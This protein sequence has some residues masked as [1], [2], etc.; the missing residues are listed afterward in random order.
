MGGERHTFRFV[1]DAAHHGLRIDT[2]LASRLRNHAPARLQRLTAAGLVTVDDGPCTPFRRVAAG[3]EVVVRLAEPSQPFYPPT[4]CEIDVLYDDP[5]LIAVNKPAGMIVHP[6][7]PV[8]DGTL[9]NVVQAILDRQTRLPGLLRPGIVHRLDRETSGVVLVAKDYVSHAGLTQQFER[10]SVSKSYLALVAGRIVEN[11]N[12][13]DLPIGRQRGSLLMSAE[14]DAVEPRSATTSFRVIER[15]RSA[16]LVDVRPVTGRKHQI[17]VH[18]A[19]IGHAVLGDA[20]YGFGPNRS[21]TTRHAL[22]ATAIAFRHP[23]TNA[24]LRIT[25]PVPDDLWHT[26]ATPEAR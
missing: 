4:S 2:F 12:R 5:W 24:P 16:T 10:S 11:A 13:I 14:N 6:A 3:E 20:G 23:V 15:L 7:G 25:A 18:F 26:L 19:A 22:H 8:G 1:V 9:A 17:R 21:G